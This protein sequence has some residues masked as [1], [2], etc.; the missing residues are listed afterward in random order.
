MQAENQA[1]IEFHEAIEQAM[2]EAEYRAVKS[3]QDAADR[4]D[5]RAAAWKLER[6]HHDRWGRKIGVTD[7]EGDNFFGR[8]VNAWAT[9]LDQDCRD[10]LDEGSETRNAHR[11]SKI[12]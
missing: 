12:D 6:K 11:L 10:A 1:L 9:A 5:W 2:A 3:I 4:G 7:N 8:M